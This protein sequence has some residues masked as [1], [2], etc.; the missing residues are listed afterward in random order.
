MQILHS[1][2]IADLVQFSCLQ[3]QGFLDK[4]PEQPGSLRTGM[5]TL[6]YPYGKCRGFGGKVDTWTVDS[7][8]GRAKG[9]SFCAFIPCGQRICNLG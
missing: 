6:G 5:A 3:I 1:K 9:Q 2:W 8:F 4:P 7:N